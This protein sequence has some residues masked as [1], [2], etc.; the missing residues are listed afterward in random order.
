MKKRKQLS[1][2][3]LCLLLFFSVIFIRYYVLTPIIV[4]G[5]SMNPTLEDEDLILI[6]KMTTIDHFDIVVFQDQATNE[7][8]VKRVIGIP[9]DTI[10]YKEDVLYINGAMF[11][12]TYLNALRQDYPYRKLV[13]NLTLEQLYEVSVLPEDH[14]FVLGDNRIDSNDSRYPHTIGL[15][16]KDEILGEVEMIF[17]PF[18]HFQWIK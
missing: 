18:P 8:Y 13:G 11:E 14:Y 17:Y 3:S 16:T 12:E 10:E 15:V 7:L 6:N 1:F 4:D 9:G 2:F 5:A